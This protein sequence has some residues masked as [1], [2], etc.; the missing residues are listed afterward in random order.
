M[1]AGYRRAVYRW[2]GWLAGLRWWQIVLLAVVL[3][4]PWVAGCFAVGLWLMDVVLRW[5]S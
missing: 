4:P 5:W 1:W 3:I 2:D